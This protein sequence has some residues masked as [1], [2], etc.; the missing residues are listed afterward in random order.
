M[1]LYVPCYRPTNTTQ[2]SMSPV[3]FFFCPGFFPFDSFLFC[4]NPFVL[5]VTLRSILP[6]LQQTQHKHSCPGG[7]FFCLSGVFPL[8]S[9]FVLFK[10]FFVLHVTL[11]SMLPSS[12]NKH[13]TN[14]HVPGG[15]RTHN[16]RKQ[17]SEVPRLRPRD[18]WGIK[19]SHSKNSFTW[20]LGLSPRQ[21]WTLSVWQGEGRNPHLWSD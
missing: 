14:I 16:P 5:H 10:S 1:S 17:T 18:H 21:C 8:W 11:R 7:I 2:T 15:I 6:S 19:E 13:N 4:L 3:G 20:D 12:Y 9:I